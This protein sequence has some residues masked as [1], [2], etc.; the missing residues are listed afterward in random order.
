MSGLFQTISDDP[1]EA[2]VSPSFAMSVLPMRRT[3]H[4]FCDTVGAGPLAMGDI[5]GDPGCN[6]AGQITL[7]RQ[8]S[9]DRGEHRR[10][11]HEADDEVDDYQQYLDLRKSISEV[12]PTAASGALTISETSSGKP[13][14]AVA[15]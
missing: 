2:G 1:V 13:I 12:V 7:V 11:Q 9:V 8:D 14:A 5:R 3:S 10:D 4:A 15:L 6:R